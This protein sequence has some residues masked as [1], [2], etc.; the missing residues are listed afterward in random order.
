MKLFVF[1]GYTPLSDTWRPFKYSRLPSNI[2]HPG[3]VAHPTSS[4][5]AYTTYFVAL[6]LFRISVLVIQSRTVIPFMGLSIVC[7]AICSFFIMVLLKLKSPYYNISQCRQYVL[8]ED[9]CFKFIL[10]LRFK[11]ILIS[12][13]CPL[14]ILSIN[15]NF[16]HLNFF[17]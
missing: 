11:Y 10:N 3:N 1:M 17:I 6:D 4:Q 9:S 7:C 8:V 12:T 15:F 16:N 13:K 2:V 14:I 5:F